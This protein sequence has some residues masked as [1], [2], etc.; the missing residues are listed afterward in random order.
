M[1]Q[2]L[3]IF[4]KDA[5]RLWIEIS[6][7]LIMAVAFVVFAPM[8]WAMS[9]A[10]NSSLFETLAGLT[11]ALITIFWWLMIARVV[12]AE[13]MV[14]DTQFWIT[15]PYRSGQLF[16]AKALFLAA[17]VALPFFAMQAALLLRAG[18]APQLYLP[19]LLLNILLI[20]AFFVLPMAALAVVTSNLVRLLLT[21]FGILIGFVIVAATFYT[22]F[23]VS[24]G[25]ME[26]PLQSNLCFGVAFV[27]LAA[28]VCVQY[29]TRKVWRARALLIALPLLIVAA[30]SFGSHFSNQ[31]VERSFPAKYPGN[32]T[33][34][35][36]T[37]SINTSSNVS[38]SESLYFR[39]SAHVR[40]PISVDINLNGI[41]KGSLVDVDGLRVDFTAPSGAHWSSEWQT[42]PGFHFRDDAKTASLIVFIPLE[43]YNRLKAEPLNMRLSLAITRARVAQ[44]TTLPLAQGAFPV[45]ALGKCVVTGSLAF[46]GQTGDL[47]CM[48][49]ISGSPLI[50]VE[51]YWTQYGCSV[52]STATPKEITGA[53]TGSLYPEKTEVNLLP[54]NKQDIHLF[55]RSDQENLSLCPGTQATFTQYAPVERAQLQVSANNYT[56]VKYNTRQEGNMLHLWR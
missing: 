31:Q 3:H 21:L 50:H 1:K 48:N 33:G 24:Y 8:A 11:G 13:R 17:F 43:D 7:S 40:I 23:P 22:V 30:A 12:H 26:N 49:P 56:L 38:K 32:S 9:N 20:L 54:L 52:D 39:M 46:Q 51:T 4:A 28:A 35:W 27:M 55:K 41:K 19:G 15:R 45:P 14:G 37:V 36:G 18:F 47:Q 6:L 53:W 10:S 25:R 42:G 44:S 34:E 5:R 2:A 16:A 29:A